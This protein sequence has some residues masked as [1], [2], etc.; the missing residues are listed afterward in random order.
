LKKWDE[1]VPEVVI[2]SEGS[3]DQDNDWILNEEEVDNLI[4]KYWAAK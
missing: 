4:K 3:E 2:A 1:D